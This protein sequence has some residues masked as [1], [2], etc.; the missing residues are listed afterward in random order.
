VKRSLAF[1]KI[2]QLALAIVVAATAW[3]VYRSF[4]FSDLVAIRVD[5]VQAEQHSSHHAIRVALPDLSSLRGHRPVLV[6]RLR[7]TGSEP[8]RITLVLGGFPHG[9]VTLPPSG[10]LRWDVPLSPGVVQA[11]VAEADAASR[12]VELRSDADGWTLSAL[13]IRN[14]HLRSGNRFTVVVLPVRAD[15]YTTGAGRLTAGIVLGVVAL[16]S[17]LGARP[18]TGT[19][20]LASQ[21]LVL[22]AFLLCVACLVLPRVSPYK[23]LVSRS[24]FWALAAA[25]FSPAVLYA[26]TPLVARTGSIL[27]LT[28]ARFIATIDAIGRRVAVVRPYWIRHQVTLERGSALV[29]LGALGIGQPILDVISNSPEFFAARNTTLTAAVIAVVAICFGVPLLLLAVERAIRVASRPAAAIFHAAMLALLSAAVVMPWFRRGEV[30]M[31]PWDALISALAGLIVALA[32]A[33]VRLV[34]QFLTA[35]ATTALVVPPVFL[36]DPSVAQTFLTSGSAVAVQTVGR[37]PPIV[38]VIFDELPLNSLLDAD[39]TIDAERYPNFAALARDAYWFRNAG[40]VSSETVWAVPAILSGRYPTTSHAVPTL[41]Y[42]PANLFTMLA[43]HY[44]IYAFLR[45][46]KLCPAGA[47]HY[48][49]AIA[50]DTVGSLLSDFGFVWLHIVLPEPFTENLPPIVGDWAEFGRSRPTRSTR[51]RNSRVAVFTQ[52]LSTIDGRPARL[53][54]IHLLLP[55]MLFEFVP[56]G[57]QYRAPDYQARLEQGSRLFERASAAYADTL[58]QRHLAQVGYVDRLVGDLLSR[59]RDV[60]SYN[61][62]LIIITADHGASYREGHARRAAQ[63]HNR[64]EIMHVPLLVKLPGQKRGEI[65]DRIVETVDIVP[66]ILDVLEANVSV[67]LDGRSLIDDRMPERSARTFIFR[68]RPNVAPR[69]LTDS[70]ADRAASLARKLRRFGSGDLTSLYAPPGTRHLLGTTV[71]R[72]SMG[73]PPDVG[74][75]LFDRQRFAAVKRDRDPLPLYVRGAI[76]TSRSEPLRVAVVVNGIVAAVTESY[77]EGDAHV[78]GTLIPERILRDGKNTVDAFIVDASGLKDPPS[79]TGGGI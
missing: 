50:A 47:C 52:F 75:T 69:A 24:A 26:A 55:H 3:V 11:L 33:R 32:Y 31:W 1:P 5:V 77:R 13:E 16:L 71:S 74:I 23:V 63:R 45:F 20:R 38:L 78:F 58:H 12:S 49:S 27:R 6:F 29:A 22:V 42:Y 9:R 2:A 67:R 79:T 18:R 46:R 8:R 34:R 10:A 25:L 61:E 7:N 56:S 4:V 72:A 73:P 44:D 70:S 19:L 68:D 41:R 17:A 66:T 65:V 51:P 28:A 57:R 60:G 43:R 35:L 30:L 59:L 36:L 37:T 64:S 21:G 15:A 53:H 40:T 48:N 62:T 54:L 76:T 14:Y 39:G